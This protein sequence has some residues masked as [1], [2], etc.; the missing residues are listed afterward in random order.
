MLMPRPVDI[1]HFARDEA[2]LALVDRGADVAGQSD[3][4]HGAAGHGTAAEYSR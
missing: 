1:D 4:I 2:E 3:L